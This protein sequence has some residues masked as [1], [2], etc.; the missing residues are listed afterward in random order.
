MD[1]LSEPSVITQALKNRRG[2]RTGTEGGQRDLIQKHEKDLTCCCFEYRWPL[3][4]ETKSH[5]MDSKEMGTSVLQLL[6]T[7]FCQHPK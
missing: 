6:R 5:L 1:Y 4:A 7:E 3:E 2:R